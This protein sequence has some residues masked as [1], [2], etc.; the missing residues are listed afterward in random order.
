MS[1]A[2]DSS[3]FK[4]KKAGVHL[5]HFLPLLKHKVFI[6]ECTPQEK[7]TSLPHHNVNSLKTQL[8]PCMLPL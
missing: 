4:C 5:E 6:L 1:Q 3:Q 7:N 8:L 2:W